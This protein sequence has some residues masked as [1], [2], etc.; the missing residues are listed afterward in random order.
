MERVTVLGVPMHLHPN[1]GDYLQE[2]CEGGQGTQVITLNAEM[3]MQAR[4]NPKLLQVIERAELVVPDGAGVVLYL[5]SLGHRVNRCPGIELAES[6][7]QW[8]E[9]QHKSLFLVGGAE[10]IT[11]AVAH[12]WQSQYPDIN[13]LGTQHGFFLQDPSQT[14]ALLTQLEKLQ[15]DIIL[16]GLGVPRQEFWIDEQ[17]RLCPKSVWIGVGG[18]FDVWSG[19]KERAPR[20][21]RENNLEWSYRLYKEPWRWRRMLSLPK[22]ALLA[23]YDRLFGKR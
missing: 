9:T 14:D 20:W 8:A 6:L 18:S 19:T 16:V 23:L 3:V 21:L 15:P 7:V 11:A 1:Y 2:L 4:H 13:I 10:G 5:R 12:R 22:F 17:R